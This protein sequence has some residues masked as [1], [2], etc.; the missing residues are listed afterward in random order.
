MIK[1]SHHLFCLNKS[2]N[3]DN[4]CTHVTFEALA[5]RT[6]ELGRQAIARRESCERRRES[7]SP[8]FATQLCVLCQKRL[9]VLRKALRVA[10]DE[11][12]QSIGADIEPCVGELARVWVGG[13][14]GCVSESGET[15]V[16]SEIRGIQ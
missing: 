16:Y 10:N 9:R 13:S 5:V 2:S 11:R 8:H 4:K 14:E 3:L 1:M 15:Q 12:E 7:L 6:I